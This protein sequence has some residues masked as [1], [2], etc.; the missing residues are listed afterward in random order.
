M[1]NCDWCGAPIDE[2]G[3][4]YYDR[5]Q[6]FDSRQCRAENHLKVYGEDYVEP[7]TK[8]RD[9]RKSFLLAPLV[10]ELEEMTRQRNG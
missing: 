3:P 7:V 1:T 6:T 5:G 8:R 10:V 9:P 2:D 4:V